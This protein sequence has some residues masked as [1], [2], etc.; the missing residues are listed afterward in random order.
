MFEFLKM[1]LEFIAKIYAKLFNLPF[2][3]S[4][5]YGH[6]LIFLIFLSLIIWF[7]ISRKGSDK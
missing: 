2:H 7:F 4:I 5:T 6:I 3:G 1:F